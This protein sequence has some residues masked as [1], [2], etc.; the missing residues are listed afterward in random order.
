[1][2][3]FTEKG[4][5]YLREQRLGRLATVGK[6]GG[7]HVVPLSFRYNEER[8]TID[9]GG[10]NL[11]KSKKFRDV[12]ATGR[13]ALVVDDVAPGG[14]WN[15]RGVE[16]RGSAEALSS[17]GGEVNADFDEELIR[18]HPKRVVGWG[19]DSDAYAPNSRSVG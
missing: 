15:P 14:G 18:I 13:A 5:E 2:S 7:P 10:H 1:M 19:L 4:I 6:N 17:G 8:D 12:A 11:G 3:A 9:I 16:V